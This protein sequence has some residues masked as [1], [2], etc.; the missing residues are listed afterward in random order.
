MGAGLDKSDLDGGELLVALDERE[1]RRARQKIRVKAMDF[2]ARR[3]YGCQELQ[4]RLLRRNYDYDPERVELI[5]AELVADNLL[6]D[7]RFVETF[8]AS[9]QR[10][11]QGP[12]RIRAELRER[13]INQELIE[14]WLDMRDPE[15]MRRLRELHDK[16]FSG[17]QPAMLSE[18][19]RQQRFFNYRGFTAEQIK[20]LFKQ[21]ADDY[22]E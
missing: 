9:R 2:L 11:G 4:Q 3:E 1:E 7:E 19:A 20:H 6:S 5:I 15:W 14:A 16:R 18:R 17:Q 22:F 8:V 12:L 10:R 21:D 13:G